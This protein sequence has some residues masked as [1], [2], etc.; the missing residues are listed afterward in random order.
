MMSL[1][2]MSIS[3]HKLK[4]LKYAIIFLIL[5]K[6][7]FL[8]CVMSFQSTR[9]FLAGSQT[10]RGQRIISPCLSRKLFLGSLDAVILILRIN[11]CNLYDNIIFPSYID[12]HRYSLTRIA[13]IRKFLM[14]LKE[15]YS[16]FFCYNTAVFYWIFKDSI[17]QSISSGINFRYFCLV[18]SYSWRV[19][20]K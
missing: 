11:A 2:I 16:I 17:K 4:L 14:S 8:A 1:W 5:W 15:V 12:F 18:F 10:D 9:T 13:K 20:W 19:K 6:S 3:T 7:R